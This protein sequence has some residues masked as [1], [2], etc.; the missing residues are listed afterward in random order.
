MMQTTTRERNHV[1]LKVLES[2][3]PTENLPVLYARPTE[4]ESSVERVLTILKSRGLTPKVFCHVDPFA[5]SAEIVV[6]SSKWDWSVKPLDQSDV[7]EIPHEFREALLF[8][9]ESQFPISGI[10]QATP[11]PHH[12]VG[13]VAIEESARVAQFSLLAAGRALF[14]ALSLIGIVAL[15]LLSTMSVAASGLFKDPD[16]V[17]LVRV[18]NCFIE[19]GRWG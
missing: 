6:Q 17:L 5:K 16:P 12:T 4:Q 19:I 1:V 8:L 14:V 7:P 18:D 11:I 3:M 2:G 9:L 13:G 10:A 15:G